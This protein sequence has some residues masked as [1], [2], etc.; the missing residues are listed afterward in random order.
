M[1]YVRLTQMC[2]DCKKTW[3]AS[4][5]VAGSRSVHPPAECP[6]CKGHRVVKIASGWTVAADTEQPHTE[7][8]NAS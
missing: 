3:N 5:G 8:A 4:Y 7:T 1:S 6:R 2:E